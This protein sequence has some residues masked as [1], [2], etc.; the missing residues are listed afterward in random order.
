[1]KTI[2]LGIITFFSISLIL[3]GCAKKDSGSGKSST[4]DSTATDTTDTYQ[5]TNTPEKTSVSVPKSLSGAGSASS[6]TANA[7]VTTEAMFYNMLKGGVMM[8]KGS[9]S[10]ADLNLTLADAV[11]ATSTKGQCYEKESYNITF[12]QQMYNALVK[13]EQEFGGEEGAD[14]SMSASMKQFIGK[15]FPGPV[16]Y[17]LSDNS[18]GGYSTELKVGD[19][20]S[21]ISSG[22]GVETFRWDTDKKKLNI[23]FS[24]GSDS[25]GTF[26]GNIAFDSDKKKSVINMKVDSTEMKLKMVMNLAECSDAQKEGMTGNCAVFSF[27][28]SFTSESE[29]FT[30]M[31]KGDGKADDNGGY[32]VAAMSFTMSGMSMKNEYKERWDGKGNLT[33]L[34]YKNQGSSDW[35]E[36]GTSDS[37]YNEDSYSSQGF[38]ISVTSGGSTYST[39]GSY[40]LVLDGENPN[41]KPEAVVGYGEIRGAESFWDFWGGDSSATLDLWAIPSSGN[42]TEVSGAS[43]TVTAN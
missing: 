8:M 22:S 9:I 40:H 12:T 17:Q 13:M 2:N 23:S 34:A 33:Y 3:V 5:R 18:E 4:D 31:M 7:E 21:D 29:G 30:G 39:E 41:T 16:S 35:T 28:Q 42:M 32:G 25:E 19:T 20:C 43:I 27:T 1:M 11:I 36:E 37:T 24:D 14:A 26:K 6:R 38:T 15:E 10:S